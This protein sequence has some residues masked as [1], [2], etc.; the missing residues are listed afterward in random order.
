MR[1]QCVALTGLLLLSGSAWSDDASKGSQLM[2][3]FAKNLPD[4]QA[5]R[6]VVAYIQTLRP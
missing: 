3:N 4:D 1:K 5:M 2:S 6:D